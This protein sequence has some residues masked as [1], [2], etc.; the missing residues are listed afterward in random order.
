MESCDD[1]VLESTVEVV[2]E[3]PERV[4]WK[5]EWDILNN[6]A[7]NDYAA[8]QVG[9]LDDMPNEILRFFSVDR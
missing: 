6:R 9:K 1:D 5:M 4:I 8:H 7:V 2:A 3:A